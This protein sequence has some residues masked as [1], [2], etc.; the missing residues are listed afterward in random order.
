MGF[1]ADATDKYPGEIARDVGL[2][3]LSL[4]LVWRPRTK[5]ALDSYIFRPLTPTS[6]ESDHAER[7]TPL[8][9]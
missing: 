9:R 1:D 3:L 8:H 2:L 6:R 4:W 7:Q 5:L